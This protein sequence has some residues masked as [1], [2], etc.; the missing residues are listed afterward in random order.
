MAVLFSPVVFSLSASAPIAEL[1]LAVV[2]FLS[3]AAPI[4]VRC[5]PVVFRKSTRKPMA[6]LKFELLS[7]SASA[8][9]PC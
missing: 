2:L 8:Q 6:K 5:L 3:A 7:L 1:K 4:P 9:W